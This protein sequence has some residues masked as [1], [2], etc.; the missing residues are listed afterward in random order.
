MMLPGWR[1]SRPTTL[2]AFL[3][4]DG[5]YTLEPLR[6]GHRVSLWFRV[7][8]FFDRM[9]RNDVLAQFAVVRKAAP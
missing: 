5:E 4:L 8:W 9:L 3:N 1:T 2:L 6:P 7:L